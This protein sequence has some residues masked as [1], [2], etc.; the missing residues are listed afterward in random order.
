MTAS[1]ATIAFGTLLKVGD[2]ASPENFT[3]IAEIKD[4]T[5]PPQTR[6]F[7]D[8][9][10]M[11]SPGKVREFKP[12]VINPGEIRCKC[13]F[14]PDN[15][16]QG[17]ATSGIIKDFQDGTA[18]NYQIHYPTSPSHTQTLALYVASYQPIGPMTGAFEMDVTFKVSGQSN[19]A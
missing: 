13:N 9:T 8:V 4:I 17:F 14:L 11:Q 3:A 2:G 19:W 7:A 1:Q 5:P 12:T 16:T 18:R 6:E 10:H 15:S